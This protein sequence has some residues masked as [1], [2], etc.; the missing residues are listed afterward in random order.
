MA[1]ADESA[2][3]FLQIAF[4]SFV[5]IIINVNKKA[6]DLIAYTAHPILLP[7]HSGYLRKLLSANPAEIHLPHWCIRTLRTYLYKGNPYYNY[8]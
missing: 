5:N 1:K 4:T 6:C 8:G 7:K 3:G 2:Q